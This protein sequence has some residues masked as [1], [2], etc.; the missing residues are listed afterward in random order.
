MQ[1]VFSPPKLS[2]VCVRSTHPPPPPRPLALALS[3]ALKE[4]DPRPSHSLVETAVPT[5][6]PPPSSHVQKGHALRL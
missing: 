2:E 5:Q 4:T 3:S 6:D 1:A